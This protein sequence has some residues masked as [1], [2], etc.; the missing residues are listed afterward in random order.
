M[1]KLEKLH[2]AEAK[3]FVKIFRRIWKDREFTQM[4]AGPQHMY[5]L[6]LSQPNINL[7]GLIPISLTKWA[8]L[9]ANTG[10]HDVRGYIE[11]L[12][13]RCFVVADFDT[14]E[15]LVRTVIR[16]DS[17]SNQSWTLQIGILRQCLKADSPRIRQVLADEIETCLKLGM[18]TDTNCVDDEAQTYA[19]ELRELG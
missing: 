2:E 18:F 9:S 15:L 19:D 3:R 13:E 16:N 11:E 1:N 14:G 5:L 7:A 6:L 10:P 12:D 8:N 4:D 17:L